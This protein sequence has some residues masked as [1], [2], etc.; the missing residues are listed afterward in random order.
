MTYLIRALLLL[1]AAG[2]LL[3]GQR[4]TVFSE[5]QRPGPGGETVSADRAP[6][7]RE[8]LS[9]ALIRNG[10]ASFLFTVEAPPGE[11]YTIY[12]AQNPDN[13]AKVDLYQLEYAEGG[14]AWIPDGLKP[15]QQPVQAVLSEGQKTQAYLLDLFLPASTPVERFRLEIQLH[16]AGR[17]TIYPMEMRPM[18]TVA[19][20]QPPLRGTLAPLGARADA[21]ATQALRAALCGAG[22]SAEVKLGTLRAVILRNAIQDLAIARRQAGGEEKVL[23]EAFLRAGGWTAREALCSAAEPAPR[24]PEWWLRVRTFLYQ[25]RLWPE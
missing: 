21:T 23:L 16:A 12:A 20:A 18:E 25:G 24:G 14:G 3:C 17:W 5:F 6:A 8:I 22:E 15:V 2:S 4:V 10:W 13:T 19:P 1:A 9:P 7:R 11:S